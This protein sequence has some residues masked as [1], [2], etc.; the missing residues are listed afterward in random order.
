MSDQWL[1]GAFVPTVQQFFLTERVYDDDRSL[2]QF[3]LRMT[4][5][6][7]VDPCSD[8]GYHSSLQGRAGIHISGILGPDFGS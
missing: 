6:T 7:P 3:E 4:V 2:L 1:I 8:P 5:T